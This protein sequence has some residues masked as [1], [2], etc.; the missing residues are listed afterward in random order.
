MS[1]RSS[2][3]DSRP[4]G[5][6]REFFRR[7]S[8]IKGRLSSCAEFEPSWPVSIENISLSG[9]RLVGKV[10][11]IEAENLYLRI[12]H[13]SVDIACR[14]ITQIDDEIR[15]KV[16]LKTLDV[17]QLLRESDLYAALT[18]E[19]MPESLGPR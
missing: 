14:R 5:D 11:Q 6:R 17:A 18:L 19:A 3:K 2:R 13:T 12:E 10:P 4:E 15:V 16:E 8:D 9:M 1:V 7:S